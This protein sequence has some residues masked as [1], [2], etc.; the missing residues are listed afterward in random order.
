MTSTAA[1]SSSITASSSSSST[2]INTPSLINNNEID[3]ENLLRIIRNQSLQ[4]RRDAGESGIPTDEPLV[5]RIPDPLTPQIGR[6][7]HGYTPGYHWLY[8]YPYPEITHTHAW[9]M[10]IC[11]G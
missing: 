7:L 11:R 6:Q 4:A 9:G 5:P 3:A 2:S 10:G 1:P 8:L